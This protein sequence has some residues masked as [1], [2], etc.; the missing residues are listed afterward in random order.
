L[1]PLPLI[2]L[3]ERVWERELV[4]KNFNQGETAEAVKLIRGRQNKDSRVNPAFSLGTWGVEADFPYENSN[5]VHRVQQVALVVDTG[6]V[7]VGAGA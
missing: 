6:V 4:P 1:K 7:V 3:R 2:P 5:V